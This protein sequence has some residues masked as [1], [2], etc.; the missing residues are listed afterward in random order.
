MLSLPKLIRHHYWVPR[1]PDFVGAQG[2]GGIFVQ[3]TRMTHCSIC[4]NRYLIST[5][6][7]WIWV[8]DFS[9]FETSFG[10]L[11][12]FLDFYLWL[13]GR[14]D[15][16][17]DDSHICH[18]CLSKAYLDQSLLK[19]NLYDWSVTVR[20]KWWLTTLLLVFVKSKLGTVTWIFWANED[21]SSV[22]SSVSVYLR[23]MLNRA[24]TS[25]N[26]MHFLHNWYQHFE[27]NLESW[28]HPQIFGKYQLQCSQCVCII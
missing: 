1:I 20:K 23:A 24:K 7:F 18:M 4:L 12:I 6:H 3:S 16:C 28:C 8:L 10:L 19:E 22:F 2:G 13:T 21:G 9:H 5:L 11:N 15:I 25:F 26:S 17:W 14:W 27:K